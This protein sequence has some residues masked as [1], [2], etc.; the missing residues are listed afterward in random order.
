MPLNCSQHGL[1]CLFILSQH[2]VMCII[3]QST[4]ACVGTFVPTVPLPTITTSPSGTVQ[5]AMVGDPLLVQ[6]IVDTVDGVESSLVNINWMGPGGDL[7]VNTSRETVSQITSSNNTYNSSLHFTSLYEDD[8][9]VYMCFV[10]ILETNELSSFEIQAL[11]GM[12][13]TH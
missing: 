8:T 10:M 7:I 5:G 12:C 1:V 2:M 3:R 4:Y 11:A 9:G 13:N 6:C